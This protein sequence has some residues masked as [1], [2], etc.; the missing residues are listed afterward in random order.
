MANNERSFEEELL[1]A[2]KAEKH[3]AF[4][5]RDRFAAGRSDM[6]IQ[7]G[8][9]GG[10]WVELKYGKTIHRQLELT[11]PQRRFGKAIQENGGQSAW[12]CCVKTDTLQWDVFGSTNFNLAHPTDGAELWRR[13][14]GGQWHIEVILRGLQTTGPSHLR[15]LD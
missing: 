15:G 7:A 5:V 10:W 8:I 3:Y 4:V 1:A 6:Y 2:C 13:K 11:G 9:L 14:R 12:L